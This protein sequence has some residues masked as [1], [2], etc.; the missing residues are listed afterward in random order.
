MN[1]DTVFTYT[2]LFC[3]IAFVGAMFLYAALRKKEPDLAWHRH[4]KVSTSQFNQL[5][6][7]GVGLFLLLFGVILGLAQAPPEVGADGEPK[8]VKITPMVMVVGMISQQLVFVFIVLA[9][10]MFRNAKLAEMFGLKWKKVWL[11]IPIAIVTVAVFYVIV[12]AA[13]MMGYDTWMKETFGDDAKLQETIRVYKETD[14]A[15]IRMMMAF[16][17]I[18]LAPVCEE[19]LFRGYIYGATKRFSDRFFACLFS[20]LMFAVVHYNINALLPLFV[21]A[22]LLT[23]AYEL[24]GS[25]WAPISIHALFNTTTVINMELGSGPAG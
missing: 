18:V 19:I 24:T 22:I 23:I 8:E 5:D 25:I 12:I 13:H 1:A 11:A 20:S 14:A 16:A 9:L 6:I 4:G 2:Y 17:V 15:T 10:L 3:V 21:L 7:F